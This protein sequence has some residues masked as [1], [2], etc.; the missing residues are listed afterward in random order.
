MTDDLADLRSA[1]NHVI[2]REVGP[3]ALVILHDLIKQLPAGL[4]V[5]GWFLPDHKSIMAERGNLTLPVYYHLI[6]RLLQLGY[7]ERKRRMEGAKRGIWYRINF[8]RMADILQAERVRT[9]TV[10]RETSP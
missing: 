2:V 3:Q 6:A 8:D 10:S 9:L 5:Q 1:L 4:H 7:I